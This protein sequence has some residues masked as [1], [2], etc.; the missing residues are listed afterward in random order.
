MPK[1]VELDPAV[2]DEAPTEDRV[3]AYDDQHHVTYL[4][5]LD[6]EKEGADWKEVAKIVLHRDPVAEEQRSYRCWKSHL[7]R[8]Q[9]FAR[10]GYRHLVRKSMN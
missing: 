2:A 7:E 10:S 5:V 1:P 3:T 8:A 4:R 6:A 9:W